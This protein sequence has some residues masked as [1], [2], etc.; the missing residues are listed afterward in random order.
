M[1]TS[2]L[3]SDLLRLW[4]AKKFLPSMI[5]IS[6]GAYAL[7]IHTGTSAETNVLVVGVASLVLALLLE[8]LMPYRTDWNTPRG[9]RATDWTSFAVLAGAAEPLVKTAMGL[10]VVA[11][12]GHQATTTV[13]FAGALPLIV[14]IAIATLLIELGKYAAHRWHHASPALWWLHA[15]HH[16]AVRMVAVNNFRYHPL[17]YA[18]N[19]AL[20]MLPL[21]LLGAPADV[22][23]GY[24]AITQP[25]VMVQHANIDL[26]NDWLSTVLSTPE[27]HRRHHAN[28]RSLGDCNFGN[29]LLIWDHVFGTYMPVD[30]ALDV[31]SQVG[32]Y[33]PSHYPASDSY[34]QQLRS[35][36]S[37]RCCKAGAA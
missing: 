17:N 13:W 34:W 6:V 22:L 33:A 27:V 36:L 21:M 37:P 32:L 8:R 1:K 18:I 29:A 9:D 28:Q 31:D 2:A 26:R 3:L 12:Y 19:Q 16:S 20:S 25:I 7:A 15:L 23:L 35:M 5:L 30:H 24:L 4:I 10:A 14:Q 11:M